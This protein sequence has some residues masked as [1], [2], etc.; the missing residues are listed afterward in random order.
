LGVNNWGKTTEKRIH[1]GG[2]GD[3]TTE[4]KRQPVPGSAPKVPR[5]QQKTGGQRC[6]R[7]DESR[8]PEKEGRKKEKKKR[9][10][11]MQNIERRGGQQKKNNCWDRTEKQ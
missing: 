9:F 3:G 4:G 11:S 5:K 10:A 1:G 6:K 7:L 2:R 8:S